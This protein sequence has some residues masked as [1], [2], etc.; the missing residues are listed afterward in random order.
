MN[1]DMD[2]LQKDYKVYSMGHTCLIMIS[3]MS[4]LEG[5]H[6]LMDPICVY[7]HFNELFNVKLNKFF[8]LSKSVTQNCLYNMFIRGVYIYLHG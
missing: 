7:K 5:R 4:S 6:L 2:T 3:E 8:T 1:V